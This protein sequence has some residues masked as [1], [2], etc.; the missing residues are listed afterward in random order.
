MEDFL[1]KHGPN[2]ND[3]A[4]LDLLIDANIKKVPTVVGRILCAVYT[5]NPDMHFLLFHVC[6]PPAPPAL[7]APPPYTFFQQPLSDDVELQKLNAGIYF[8]Y[9][10]MFI[11]VIVCVMVY[12][13]N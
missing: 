8:T 6:A 10:T 3:Y 11:V 2:Q 5:I 4:K 12:I 1:Y 9:M 7:P 13:L